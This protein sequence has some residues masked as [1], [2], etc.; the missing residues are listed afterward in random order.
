MNYAAKPTS[1]K[2]Q[3][4]CPHR[5]EPLRRRGRVIDAGQHLKWVEEW[6]CSAHGV[7][8]PGPTESK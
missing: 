7:I 4:R 3:R 8:P 5:G 6:E 1:V 2:Q